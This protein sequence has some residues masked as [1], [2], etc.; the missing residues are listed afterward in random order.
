M[1]W[2]ALALLLVPLAAH[3]V[4]TAE[5]PV[6]VMPFKNLN[7][8]Q[9]LDWLKVGIAETMIADLKR[10]GQV[11]VVERDQIDRALTEIL[12]QNAKGG[13]EDSNAARVGKLTGART[14]VVGSFQKSGDQLRIAARF[15]AVETGLVLDAA[16]ATG[17]VTGVFALQDEVISKLLGGKPAAAKAVSLAKPKRKATEKTVQAYRLYAMSLTTASDADK[18]GYLRQSLEIDPDFSY[19]ADDLAALENRMKGYVKESDK[20]REEAS[21][22]TRKALEDA[23]V[24]PEERAKRAF[25]L[26]TSSF[27]GQRYSALL[28]DAERV[29]AMDL[30]PYGTMSVK[31]YASFCM[32]QAHV[33]LKHTDLALQTGERHLKGF[34]GGVYF[35][36]VQGQMEGLINQVRDRDEG[37]E[38]ARLELARIEKEKAEA[39]EGK[40]PPH[41]ARIQGLDFQRCTAL[42][43]AHQQ[44]RAIE[45][46]AAFAAKYRD[47]SDGPSI[48]QLVFIAR[49]NE[50]LAVAELGNFTRARQLGEKLAEEDPAQAKNMSLKVVMNTWPKE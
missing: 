22:E 40:R 3:A 32:F 39:M 10:G 29:Y 6:A 30:P 42:R 49:Y 4:T 34:P 20:R 45:E 35:S 13:S 31:E 18:V 43:S 5:D 44:E 12:L 37:K 19:A 14:V 1:K 21:Q 17:P 8:E 11:K 2:L 36:A 50:V 15:V 24:T 25:T 41:P 33:L 26:L 9:G 27:S 16:K 46:C 7:E 38:K 23:A 47:V 48:K 28:R